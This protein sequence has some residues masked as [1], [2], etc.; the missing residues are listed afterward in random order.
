MRA[1]CWAESTVAHWVEQMAE[2]M[3]A[4]KAVRSVELTAA[5]LVEWWVGYWAE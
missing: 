5:W 3:V 1:A 4:W 2:W